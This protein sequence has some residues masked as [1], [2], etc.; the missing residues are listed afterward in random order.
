MDVARSFEELRE[1]PL[2]TREECWHAYRPAQPFSASSFQRLRD[3]NHVTCGIRFHH[4][5][6]GRV[7]GQERV[8]SRLN[9]LALNARR[10][11]DAAEAERLI[12]LAGDLEQDERLSGLLE[13]FDELPT[14]PKIPR[15]DAAGDDWVRTLVD[16]CDRT[17]EIA[18]TAKHSPD[19]FPARVASVGD[20]KADL[21]LK[22]G[23]RVFFA[24]VK[25]SRIKR[26]KPGDGVFV[27]LLDL[28][29]ADELVRVRPGFDVLAR[30]PYDPAEVFDRSPIR[31]EGAAAELVESLLR[32]PPRQRDVNLTGLRFLP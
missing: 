9:L 25:L 10:V 11:G 30:A 6:K 24:E 31:V 29:G 17:D 16:F 28:D 13:H 2:A 1:W 32:E 14:V 21:V 20:G 23:Q 4:R 19:H 27:Y 8:F 18:A 3:K 12:R 15:S 26:D 22:I 7:Q 5:R